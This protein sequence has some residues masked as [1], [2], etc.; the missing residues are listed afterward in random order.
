LLEIVVVLMIIVK[1]IDQIGHLREF[2]GL[3]MLEFIEDAVWICQ[4]NKLG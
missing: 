3:E 1:K 4:K 2:E